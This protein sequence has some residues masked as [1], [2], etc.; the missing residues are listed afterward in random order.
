MGSDRDGKVLYSVGPR[1]RS[2]KQL[3]G[4]MYATFDPTSPKLNAELMSTVVLDPDA[5]DTAITEYTE[6][7]RI[8]TKDGYIVSNADFLLFLASK[9]KFTDQRAFTE[10]FIS[11]THSEQTEIDKN[12]LL[13]VKVNFRDN[14]RTIY[15]DFSVVEENKN[16]SP[17]NIAAQKVIQTMNRIKTLI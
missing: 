1:T 10:S 7:A 14:Q 5:Y 15:F 12:G 8:A 13:T 6:I 16:V 9:S 4:I 2:E 3:H 11:N 17:K